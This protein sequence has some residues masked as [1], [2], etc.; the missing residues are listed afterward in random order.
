MTQPTPGLSALCIIAVE[1]PFKKWCERGNYSVG[2][3]TRLLDIS[4][5]GGLELVFLIHPQLATDSFGIRAVDRG[6]CFNL[7]HQ[8]DKRSMNQAN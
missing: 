1:E 2:L 7:D 6:V 8:A 3:L 5:Q 4:Q